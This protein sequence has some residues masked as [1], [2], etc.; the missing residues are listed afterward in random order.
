MLFSA[1]VVYFG[2][3]F[4]AAF[5]LGIL[6]VLVVAPYLGDLAAVALEVPVVLGL[7]WAVAGAVLRRWPLARPQRVVMALLAFSV[8]MVAEAGLSVLVFGQSLRGFL[9]AMAT[10]PGALGLAGQIGFAV[11]PSLR[12]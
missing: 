11:I 7:A 2:V 6:R 4:A 10:L 5:A 9:A 12:R 8:L 1:V 3:V